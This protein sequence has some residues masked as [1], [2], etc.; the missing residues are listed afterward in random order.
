MNRAA[1]AAVIPGV[2]VER[3]LP[4]EVAKRSLDLCLAMLALPFALPVMALVGIAVRLE[5]P[6]S[7]LFRQ[8]RI[9]RYGR[10]FTV[11]KLRTMV[12]DAERLGAGIYAERDDPRFTRVGLLARRFSLD[13]LP[14]LLNVLRGEMSIVGPRPMLPVTV[15]EYEED[16]RQILRVRPGITGLAQVSGRNALSR[17]RR[18]ELD[19][20]YASEWSIAGDVRIILKT[21]RVAL[22]GEG[23]QNYQSREDVE[24]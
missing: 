19:R 22:R 10:P 17:R 7:V 4:R 18:L 20:H 2:A 3:D 5:T 13:E 14:Q 8:R 15:T 21:V 11:F 6:G 1:C 9:G 24:R 23:Q 12:R 16:Y